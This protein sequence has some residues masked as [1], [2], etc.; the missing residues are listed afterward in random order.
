MDLKKSKKDMKNNSNVS[1]KFQGN[2]LDR[3]N[4][5]SVKDRK[6]LRAFNSAVATRF[7]NIISSNAGIADRK[8]AEP[9]NVENALMSL[10]KK[11]SGSQGNQNRFGNFHDYDSD[12]DSHGGFNS[13]NLNADSHF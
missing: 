3:F 13:Y 9:D 8:E 1:R 4:Y 12:N 10:L 6:D 2:L 11:K 7:N 5:K